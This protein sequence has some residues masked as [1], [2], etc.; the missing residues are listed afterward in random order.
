MRLAAGDT[1]FADPLGIGPLPTLV[2]A[3]CAEFLCALLV[4][5]GFKTSW[6]A[7]PVVITMAVAALVQH[8]DDPF[9]VKELAVAYGV[10]FLALVFTGGGAWS[11]DGQWGRRRRKR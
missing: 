11:L 4:V 1:E 7:V 6:A 5:I 8:A 9:R 2:L 10:V 3:A